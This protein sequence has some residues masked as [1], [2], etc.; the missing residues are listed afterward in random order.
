MAAAGLSK[1]GSS[2]SANIIK[3]YIYLYVNSAVSFSENVLAYCVYEW[4][5]EQTIYKYIKLDEEMWK[6]G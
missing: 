5:N 1:S 3:I 4:M 2:F 6:L